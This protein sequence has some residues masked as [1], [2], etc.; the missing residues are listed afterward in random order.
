M[1]G[2]TALD[3]AVEE[4][5]EA[6]TLLLPDKGI[7]GSD[8]YGRTAFGRAAYKGQEAVALLLL[9]RGRRA[10]VHGCYRWPALYFA[11]EQ[12]APGRDATCTR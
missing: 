2:M 7:F 3:I 12:G 4:G 5:H 6:M 1:H 8:R 10:N 11:A 9:E